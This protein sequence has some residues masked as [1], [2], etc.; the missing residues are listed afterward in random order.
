MVTT[1][2]GAGE[3]ERKIV[4]ALLGDA[5]QVN[6]DAVYRTDIPSA[7]VTA[8]SSALTTAIAAVIAA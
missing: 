1:G 3:Q 5:K 8:I 4:L 6:D 7:L 2:G